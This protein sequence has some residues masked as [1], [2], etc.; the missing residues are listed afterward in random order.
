MPASE[1]T[2]LSQADSKQV[3]HQMQGK[4]H[5]AYGFLEVHFDALLRSA[6]Q[7]EVSRT[8]L[9]RLLGLIV[10]HHAVTLATILPLCLAR[11]PAGRA[12]LPFP[13]LHDIVLFCR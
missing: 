8:M 4:Q 5:A 10:C 9:L 1:A 7:G 3:F 6:D 2:E 12:V 11:H 13:E